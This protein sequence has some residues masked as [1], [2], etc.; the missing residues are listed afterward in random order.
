[1]SESL[2]SFVLLHVYF[3]LK[4]LHDF[5]FPQYGYAD[6]ERGIQGCFGNTRGDF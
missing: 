2:F 5:C 3:L 4:I 6:W 1:M